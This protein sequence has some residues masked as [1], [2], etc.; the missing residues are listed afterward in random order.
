MITQALDL[1]VICNMNP[2]SVYNKQN[3]FHIFIKEEQ[4]DLLLMSESWERQN[5]PL[6]QIIQLEDFEIISNVNQ[7]K[8]PGG[9]PAIIANKTKFQVQN[10]TNT[11][12]NI[13]WG[14]EAVWAI[15]MPKNASTDS[16]IQNCL[17]CI[18]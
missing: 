10:I 16:R 13:P 4:V 6:D 11:L 1:P 7:R 17:L 5:L 15:L 8:N 18:L 12:V 3:E 2:R 9:R 14:V